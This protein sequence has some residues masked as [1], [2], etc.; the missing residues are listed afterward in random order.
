M[1]NNNF[2]NPN[3][4]PMRMCL[5]HFGIKKTKNQRKKR[6]FANSK[7]QTGFVFV[8]KVGCEVSR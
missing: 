1:K 3:N 7:L 2:G 4:K 8:F 6:N 5:L